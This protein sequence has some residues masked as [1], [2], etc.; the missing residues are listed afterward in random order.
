ARFFGFDESGDVQFGKP[1]NLGAKI[2]TGGNEIS[3]F[4][5]PNN[6]NFYFA[7][8]YHTGMGGSDVFMAEIIN[9][10]AFSEP[11][12]L[13]YPVNTFNNEQ[14]LFISGDGKQAF[15]SSARNA[16]TGLDIYSFEMDSEIQPDP[17]TYINAQVIDAKT[18]QP[19]IATIELVTLAT[20]SPSK[21]IEKTGPKGELLLVL[22]TGAN[23]AFSVS[24]DGYLFFSESFSPANT[25]TFY[26]PYELLI[27]LKPI[28]VGSK[29]ELYNVYFQTDSFRILPKSEPELQK[30]VGFLE[31][32]PKLIVEI[33][34]HT[35]NTGT[36]DFN[37]S[38]SEKRAN[39]VVD[40]LVENG[41]STSRLDAAGYGENQPITTNNTD[42]GRR[43]N[44]RTTIEILNK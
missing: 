31:N 40:Y 43:L 30:L 7:S 37:Q 20:N 15:F 1:V 35:D 12:N 9:D 19:L 36:T 29:M 27:E 25:R 42:E 26:N 22:P 39:S 10:S 18:K 24:K 14:G 4:M 5:H 33:Q 23:Y 13:G 44:R 38:L 34:G 16:E 8:D 21:R 2:N 32:N 3:P 6:K 41:I 11:K 17:V 28:E